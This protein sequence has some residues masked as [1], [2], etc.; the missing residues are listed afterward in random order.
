M[1]TMEQRALKRKNLIKIKKIDL[2]SN[3]HHSFHNHLDVKESWE[4]LTRLSKEAW[5][6]QTGKTPPLRVD[7]SIYI[8]KQLD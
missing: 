7:K 5:I 4:I 6:E 8:F 3:E 2:H 1:L